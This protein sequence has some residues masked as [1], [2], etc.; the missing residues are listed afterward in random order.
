[1]V[2]DHVFLKVSPMKGVISVKKGRLS[3]RYISPFEILDKVKAVAYQLALLPNLSM[4]YPVFHIS[5]LW[6]Y[7][8]DPSYILTL[9]MVQLDENL[10]YEEEPVA[11]IDR[12]VKKLQSKNVALV[13]VI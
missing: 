5:M 11:I 10:S 7:I 8:P 12:Q 6:K 9:Q 4:I 1:M 3:P 2:G 13:K